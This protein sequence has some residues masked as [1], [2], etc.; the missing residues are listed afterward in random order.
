MYIS[1]YLS[2]SVLARSQKI[3]IRGNLQNKVTMLFGDL[4]K[5]SGFWLGR[6]QTAHTGAC[7]CANHVTWTWWYEMGQ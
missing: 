7:S 2:R 1:F 3:G 6:E 5:F 4:G